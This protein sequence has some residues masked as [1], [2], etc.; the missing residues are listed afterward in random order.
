MVTIPDDVHYIAAFKG[1]L[2]ELAKAYAWG[3]DPEHTAIQVAAKMQ[4]S[5]DGII[6]GC[7]LFD[8]RFDPENHCMIQKTT[9]GGETWQDVGS[10]YSC[11]RDAA[12]DEI[13]EAIGDG[14]IISAVGQEPPGGGLPIQECHTYHVLLRGGDR[15]LCPVAVSAQ[16]TVRVTVAVGGWGDG[17]VMWFCPDGSRYLLGQCYPNSKFYD[18]DDPLLTAYHG[19]VI[20]LFG[21]SPT[22]FDPLTAEYTIPAGNYNQPLWLQMNDSNIADNLG[23]I[24]LTVEVCNTDSIDIVLGG[25]GATAELIGTNK[26]YVSIP[27]NAYPGGIGQA[28]ST[29]EFRNPDN[30]RVCGHPE[31]T[32][33]TGWTDVDGSTSNNG[34]IYVWPSGYYG[35]PTPL[36][37]GQ[38]WQ[39][40][41]VNNYYP[42]TDVS[43][44]DVRSGSVW[45]FNIEYL[46]CD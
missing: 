24:Q 29:V 34:G 20:G 44:L 40:Y 8:I 21:E 13:Y 43:Y 5:F 10:V 33:I 41:Y 9:D 39:T 36:P 4:A 12:S 3:D 14:R 15:W 27:I 31:M 19:Q 25:I 28:Q 1:A 37:E 11:G 2:Y 30:E 18:D 42:A 32:N 17:G 23:S 35:F 46:P 6:E 45:T 16:W 22:Y 7:D 38:N 26:W